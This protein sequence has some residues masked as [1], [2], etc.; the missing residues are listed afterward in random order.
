MCTCELLHWVPFLFVVATVLSSKSS[1][2]K[3][4]FVLFF[5]VLGLATGEI[6]HSSHQTFNVFDPCFGYLSIVVA[7]IASLTVSRLKKFS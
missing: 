6:F 4:F 1:K 3:S 2:N 7:S 5:S